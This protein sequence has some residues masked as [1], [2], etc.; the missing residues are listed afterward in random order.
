MAYPIEKARQ[1]YLSNLQGEEKKRVDFINEVIKM[2]SSQGLNSFDSQSSQG[3]YK[4][5]QRVF[6]EAGY[7]LE[8][9]PGDEYHH[10]RVE[11]SW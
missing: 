6:G 11:I 8:F 3:D 7:K 1:T 10:A 5:L 2:K 4:L 9:V